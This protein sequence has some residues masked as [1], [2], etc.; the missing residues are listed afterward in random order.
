M[1]LSFEISI[2]FNNMNIYR[3]EKLKFLLKYLYIIF[4]CKYIYVYEY[5]ELKHMR[6]LKARIYKS[7]YLE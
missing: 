5:S 2:V 1:I 6:P 3:N 7:V 4:I